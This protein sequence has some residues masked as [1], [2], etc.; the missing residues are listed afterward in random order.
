MTAAYRQ[1]VLK[2]IRFE[3]PDYIPMSFVIN[4]A[5]WSVCEQEALMDLMEA[6]PFL[7][8]GFVRPQLPYEPDYANVARKDAPYK[9]DWGCIWSTTMNGITGTVT[10]HPLTD[11]ADY[12]AYKHPDPNV[13]MGIGAIDWS[14]EEQRIARRRQAGLLTIEGLRH[15]HTFLQVCDIRGYENVLFDMEDEEPLLR[16]LLT[17]I[18]N[19]NASILQRYADMGVDILTVAEDLGMQRGPMLSP[20]NFRDYILPCY[21]RLAGIAKRSG[22]LLHMHSDGDIRLLA[23]M[24]LGCGMNV[25][26][27]QDL[28]NGL[29]WIESSLKGKVCIEL[30]IDRQKV[31]PFGSPK[32][33]DALIRREVEQLGSREGGLMMIYGLYPGVPLENAAALMD[34]MEKYAFYYNT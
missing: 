4:Q 21:E 32:D 3:R 27:L 16:R 24:L 1:A 19:F 34:A 18:T 29:D 12:A 13:C 2:S 6:H 17:D 33:I 11:W 25:L 7:F 14:A 9:D 10:G 8:P 31:T 28:V 30:D 15:G 22:A 5:Y 26:N 23:D 20:A